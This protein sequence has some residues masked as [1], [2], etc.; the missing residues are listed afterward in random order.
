MRLIKTNKAMEE[1]ECRKF[2]VS[3]I[4]E[5]MGGGLTTCKP[6]VDTCKSK[7]SVVFL[8]AS[9]YLCLYSVCM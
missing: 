4:S 1:V 2:T 3:P 6:R 5:D 9:W 7:D 8:V